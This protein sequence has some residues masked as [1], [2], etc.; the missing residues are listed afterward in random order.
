MAPAPAPGPEP[1]RDRLS[2]YVPNPEAFR[3][4]YETEMCGL[5]ALNVDNARQVAVLCFP[6]RN[7]RDVVELMARH[8]VPLPDGR[9]AVLTIQEASGDAD[10]AALLESAIPKVVAAHV[11]AANGNGK[12][13]DP[14]TYVDQT[15]AT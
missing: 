13:S 11:A 6:T 3:A 1:S 2:G 15:P 5:H 9:V 4:W 8:A 7:A 12:S 10:R 14:S